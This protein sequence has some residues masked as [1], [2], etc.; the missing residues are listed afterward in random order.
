MLPSG[1]IH[2]Q[3]KAPVSVTVGS[4]MEKV[5]FAWDRLGT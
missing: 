5:L 4:T 3:V 2:L 1:S